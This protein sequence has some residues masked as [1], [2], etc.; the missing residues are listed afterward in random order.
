MRHFQ[1]GDLVVLTICESCGM[2]MENPS[3]HG[4]G[5]LENQYC[6]HCTDPNGKLKSRAEVKAGIIKYMMK[7]EKR[8]EEDARKLVEEHMKRMPAWR[9]N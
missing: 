7:T 4:G 9:Q 1:K 5:N 8:G 3:D 2:P 6:K